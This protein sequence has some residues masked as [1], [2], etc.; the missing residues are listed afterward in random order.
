MPSSVHSDRATRYDPDPLALAEAVRAGDRRALA[1]AITLAESDRPN[2]EALTADLL[3]RLGRATGGALRLGISGAPGVGKSTFIEALGLHLVECGHGVAVLAV[4]PSSPRTG[5]SILGDKT[6]M[7]RLSRHPRAFIRPSPTGATTGGVS[8]GSRE[9]IL[10][11]EAAGYD[12]V[13]VETVGVGQSEVVVAQLTDIFVL[14]LAPAA[15]DALQGIKRGIIEV[16]D[17]LLVTKADGELAAA[18][19][20]TRHDYTQAL[21]LLMPPD[22]WRPVVRCCSAVDGTGVADAWKLIGQCRD[23][24]ERSGV[25]AARRAEQDRAAVWRAVDDAL[26]HRLH[27]DAATRGR[28][29]ELERRVVAGELTPA[30]A[31]EEILG[32]MA[33][34]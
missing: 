19:E 6:R 22:D 4:D 1:R 18:A 16:A 33:G 2:H 31:A 27:I 32:L 13:I 21:T 30:E 23:L 17:L 8:K 14:L 25:L 12:L 29:A 7:E 26:R 24:R 15:G 11:C 5:G 3:N 10:L 20:R 9:A 34:R 28:V